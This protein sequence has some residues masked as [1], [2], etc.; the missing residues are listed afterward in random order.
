MRLAAA[1]AFILCEAIK[2]DLCDLLKKNL[3]VCRNE[4]SLLSTY[5]QLKTCIDWLAPTCL[6]NETVLAFS[7][8][9]SKT[10]MSGG[11][12]GGTI[13]NISNISSLITDAFDFIKNFIS[14]I[15]S[16]TGV[17]GIKSVM[18]SYW[19]CI[20]SASSNV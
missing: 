7:D 18:S 17:S 10:A 9:T 16:P 11:D 5:N 20:R 19:F 15:T 14:H 8:L 12:T 13:N 2:S 1:S 4:G 6:T 3:S